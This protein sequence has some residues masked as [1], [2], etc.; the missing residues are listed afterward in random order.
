M[1][2]SEQLPTIKDLVDQLNKTNFSDVISMRNRESIDSCFDKQFKNKSNIIAKYIDSSRVI[3]DKFKENNYYLLKQAIIK[4]RKNCI[5]MREV[6]KDVNTLDFQI[7]LLNSCETH[8]DFLIKNTGLMCS[9]SYKERREY[10]TDIYFE[11]MDYLIENILIEQEDSL[12]K[13]TQQ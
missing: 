13:T 12:W 10:N 8:R 9:S 6:E 1:I 2:I 3:L 4:T 7:K 11:I 5:S